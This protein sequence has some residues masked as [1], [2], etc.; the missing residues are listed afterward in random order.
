MGSL[1][2]RS[3]ILGLVG[4][5]GVL[6]A[7]HAY[8]VGA[9]LGFTVHQVRLVL[10][11]LV[12]EGL[13]TGEGRGRRAVFRATDRHALLHGPEADWLALAY[14]QDAGQE[15][16]DGVWHLVAF[17]VPE[18]RRADRDAL[19]DTLLAMGGAVLAP[20]LYV[21]ANDWGEPVDDALALLDLHGL[22]TTA[23]TQDL[24]VHGAGEPRAIAA[25]LWPLA[26]LAD[27]YRAFLS[28]AGDAGGLEDLDA[29]RPAAVRLASAASLFSAF[30]AVIRDDPLLPPELLPQPWPG[31]EARSVLRRVASALDDL[32]AAGTAPGLLARYDAV[33]AGP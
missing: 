21:Q 28:E 20:G 30:E 24:A 4:A 12:E 23:S 1:S 7:E 9:A 2:S 10:A 15:P 5:D 6:A 14:R 11:R 3:L 18:E 27:G 22:V 29:G 32:Q 25:R 8:D 33:F 19:R 17:S 31:A 16:W 26:D 13:L